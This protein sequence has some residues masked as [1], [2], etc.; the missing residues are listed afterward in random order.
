MAD[1]RGHLFCGVALSVLFCGGTAL[2]QD[3]PPLPSE[4]IVVTAQ[5]REQ[6][7]VDVAASL[8][9]LSE[10]QIEQIGAHSTLDLINFVP[11]LDISS[12]GFSNTPIV[13][14]I[15]PGQVST[16]LVGTIID[17]VPY[18]SSSGVAFGGSS[19]INVNLADVERVEVLLGPQG[20][21]YGANAMAG[22]ISY[23]MKSSIP[24]ELT[25]SG[26]LE[27]FST[28]DGAGSFL[29]EG[30]LALPIV[31]DR[32]GLRIS[33][34]SNE[35]GGF[36]QNPRT[37][38]AD[39]GEVTAEGGR[40]ALNMLPTS[41]LAIDI[42][43]LYQLDQINGAS[44]AD[45]GLDRQPIV[46]ALESNYA[47]LPQGRREFQQYSARITQ[48][49]GG[50]EL[51][52]LT[53]W[54]R[55]E[56]AYRSDQTDGPTGAAV[57]GFLVPAFFPTGETLYR[58]NNP[59]TDKVTQELR[60][61][62]SNPSGF[63]WLLGAFYTREN[64]ELNQSFN[65]AESEGSNP[66]VGAAPLWNIYVPSEYEEYAVFGN[67]TVPVAQHW[68]LTAGLRFSENEQRYQQFGQGPFAALAGLLPVG[69]LSESSADRV[70]YNISARY[71]LGPNSALYARVATGFRPGG[72]NTVFPDVPPSYEAD[73][74]TN[75]EAGFR[76]NMMEGRASLDFA[77]FYIDWDNIQVTAQTGGGAGYFA[78]G[79][80]ARSMGFEGSATLRPIDGLSI[81]GSLGYTDAELRE[82]V[83][84]LFGVAG[85]QLPN[86]PTW[87]GSLIAQ[88]S[89]P[90]SQNHTAVLGANYQFVGSRTNGFSANP[91]QPQY[92]M[93]DYSQLDLSA[94]LETEHYTLTAFVRN[95]TDEQADLSVAFEPPVVRATQLRPRQIGVR[96]SARY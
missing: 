51:T 85:E 73:E 60:L 45:F 63:E 14:G 37:G 72:P 9:V 3:A 61:T 41:S 82:D 68:E 17:G 74:L 93:E 62:S 42:S 11:G 84:S 94:G 8:S 46:G 12:D 28:E 88:Y 49:F 31:A 1:Q 75:Y 24:S 81:T 76:A 10:A 64:S 21:L 30:A 19:S 66:I 53:S 79:G 78:N 26:A 95:V 77:V 39:I 38:D 2:A 25:A 54:A 48:D 6:R 16:A 57:I 23:V 7:L 5:K 27:S 40:I 22:L 20:T 36:I 71:E 80:K 47:L 56:N 86:A 43:A 18:G 92:E 69:P 89:R 91:F 29:A 83:P 90:L 33:G 65:L 44:S 13:R 52:S 15:N 58:Q 55:L 4:E 67:V 50:A 32:I 35:F 59:E 96:L 34:F 70:D 87:S